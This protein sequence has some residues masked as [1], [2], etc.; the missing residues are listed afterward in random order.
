MEQLLTDT[1][2]LNYK[3]RIYIYRF[4]MWKKLQTQMDVPIIN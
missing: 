3:D 4:S 2:G 1:E